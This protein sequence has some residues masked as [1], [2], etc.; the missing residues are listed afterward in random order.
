MREFTKELRKSV[1]SQ[2]HVV[3]KWRSRVK[4]QDEKFKFK[5]KMP[6]LREKSKK[7][8]QTLRTGKETPRSKSFK[9]PAILISPWLEDA[10]NDDEASKDEDLAKGGNNG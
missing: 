5:K 2:R 6:G 9:G 10:N 7:D 8:K 1:N 3:V 4:V